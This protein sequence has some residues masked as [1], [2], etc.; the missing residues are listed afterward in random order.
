MAADPGGRLTAVSV[1]VT[2]P[3]SKIKEFAEQAGVPA[4]TMYAAPNIRS[5]HRLV[6][7]DVPVA[8]WFRA[9][10][11][12]PGMFGLETAMDDLAAAAG[13]DPIE[14]RRRN[15][16]DV[17]PMSGKPFSARHLVECL[18]TGA[19]RFGWERRRPEPGSRREGDWLIGLG[20]ASSTYPFVRIPG[21]VAR[22]RYRADGRYEVGIGAA[23]LGTGTWTSLTQI[24]AEAL[25]CPKESV[26]LAIGD[27][28][29]PN[30]TIAGGSSGTASWG[31]AII[32]AA[33]EFRE[34]FG[35]RPEPDDE[36]RA[37]SPTVTDAEN[38]SL[39]SF[40]AQF[41]EV[42]VNSRTGEVRVDRLLGV[43]SVGRV[44]NAR[45]ARSQFIGGMTMGL[46]MALH[47]ESVMDPR[48][49]HVVNHDLA[50][51]HVPACADV[52]DID[53]IWLDERDEHAGKLGA[54]GIG[55][56]GI[57]GTAAAIANAAYNATGVRVRDLPLT[58]D[59]FLR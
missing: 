28:D 6:P 33:D 54:R 52:H 9:P 53:A 4:R 32:A 2:E 35:E 47:E 50:G 12:C 51:Y 41:A 3:T 27:T 34:K 23:E 49:G 43:F 16:T 14:L 58:L 20:V 8:S 26:M 21:S 13:I 19:E 25:G 31:G 45:T 42:R 59:K 29:E 46:G 17:D 57:T 15:D 38:F 5:T 44:I 39:H 11:E 48:F 40:G 1:D 18:D 22:V 55:E 30:A 7:L 56:I 37:E 24:A 10:G 36:V